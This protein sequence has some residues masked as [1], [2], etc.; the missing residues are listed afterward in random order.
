VPKN[1]SP[2]NGPPVEN[3]SA[4]NGSSAHGSS[5]HG[6]YLGKAIL[7]SKVL[8]EHLANGT[9]NPQPGSEREVAGRKTSPLLDV[10]GVQPKRRV[11]SSSI[12]L[13]SEADNELPGSRGMD[14]YD[15]L[16]QH[17][18]VIGDEISNNAEEMRQERQEIKRTRMKNKRLRPDE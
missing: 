7:N 17:L 9:H 15:A 11:S 10:M 5:S 8:N 13:G 18:M 14:Q 3:G 6:S 4:G 2:L 1:D 16:D 12:I